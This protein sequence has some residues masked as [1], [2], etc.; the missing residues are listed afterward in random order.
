LVLAAL[1]VVAVC[2]HVL[3][4]WLF[5]VTQPSFLSPLATGE[6]LLLPPHGHPRLEIRAATAGFLGG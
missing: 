5:F 6:K 4:E 2:F 1:T 3:M